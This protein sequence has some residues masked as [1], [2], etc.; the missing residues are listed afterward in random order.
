MSFYGDVTETPHP[1]PNTEQQV[2]IA[3]ERSETYFLLSKF[4]ETNYRTLLTD[5][6]VHHRIAGFTSYTVILKIDLK[7][8]MYSFFP[9][10]AAQK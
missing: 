10:N 1:D 8:S 9:R 3:D 2:Y 5:R 7:I 4:L 6:V